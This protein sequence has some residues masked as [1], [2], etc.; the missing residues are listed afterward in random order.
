MALPSLIQR[1]V[2]EVLRDMPSGRIHIDEFR[3]R[4]LDKKIVMIEDAAE[5]TL[6]NFYDPTLPIIQNNKGHFFK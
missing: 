3:R 4:L 5:D 2:T 6:E 1:K